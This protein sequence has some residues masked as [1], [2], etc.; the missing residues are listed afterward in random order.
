MKEFIFPG[1]LSNRVYLL[2]L[3]ISC[4]LV[5][6]NAQ[7]YFNITYLPGDNNASVVATDSGYVVLN[8]GN[9]YIDY[10]ALRYF[11]KNG[12]HEKN[13]SIKLGQFFEDC[14]NCLIS[15]TKGYIKG[16]VYFFAPDSFEVALVQLDKNFD[17]TGFVTFSYH[18]EITTYPIGIKMFGPNEIMV[19]GLRLIKSGIIYQ[20]YAARLDSNLNVVWDSVYSRYPVNR[21]EGYRG[22]DVVK[23]ADGGY[24][25]SGIE[26]YTTSGKLKG[27]MLKTDSLGGEEW[28]KE[29]TGPEGNLEVLL[30]P[31][32][33][34][35]FSFITT[36]R[37]SEPAS[38]Q[39]WN[40]L[41]KG[42]VDMHG[43]IL[44]DTLI[45]PMTIQ[46]STAF[47]EPTK[48]GHYI[49]AGFAQS[50]GFKS[51]AMKFSEEGDSL[52]FRSYFHG[53]DI[54]VD[55][56][57][58]ESMAHTPDSGFIFC[59]YFMDLGQ[60]GRGAH[61]WLV[62]TDKYGCDTAGCNTIGLWE[63][64]LRQTEFSLYPNPA[65]EHVILQWDWFKEALTGPIAVRLSDIQGRVL[66]EVKVE[67]FRKNTL[68]VDLKDMATGVYV[69]EVIHAEDRV[70][71]ERLVRK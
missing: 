66:K 12:R 5:R 2:L 4:S 6:G 60:G 41:R 47:F 39:Y 45:G 3:C 10:L 29:L 63:S 69:L 28:R 70:Y 50:L 48:D 32:N 22:H 38:N 52:W 19:T 53:N 1:L 64:P 24:I 7:G 25:F 59:G 11:D 30:H 67:D 18:N 23:T 31:I 42:K 27:F 55:E 62:K 35:V 54:G 26:T 68:M 21:P 36:Q 51:F 9:P 8:Q 58:I 49:T 56:A 37:L 20:L 57:Y 71:V 16:G 61:T 17:S 13:D 34:S 65:D 15:H 14:P 43:N 33:D 46:M 40:R 44:Q